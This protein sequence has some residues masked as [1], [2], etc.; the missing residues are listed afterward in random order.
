MT[1]DNRQGF[2]MKGYIVLLLAAL[3]TQSAQ[4]VI[5]DTGLDLLK[6]S[7]QRA[8]V[9]ASLS[10]ASGAF[11]ALLS[12]IH[13]SLEESHG[14]FGYTAY[15]EKTMFKL[16]GYATSFSIAGCYTMFYTMLLMEYPEMWTR[17]TRAE[18][19]TQLAIA[20]W[21][22]Y[23]LKTLCSQLIAKDTIGKKESAQLRIILKY[24][25]GITVDS[26]SIVIQLAIPN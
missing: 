13:N 2:C 21:S 9:T 24:V 26:E 3:L 25:N 11:W 8:A 20:A 15:D 12:K 17:A 23:Q 10:I 5:S 1:I 18:V 4:A 6:N 7:A 14:T 19:A 16:A 22:G